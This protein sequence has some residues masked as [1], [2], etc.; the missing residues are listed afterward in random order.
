ML[1]RHIGSYFDELTYAMEWLGK[2]QDTFFIGQ[3]VGY[4]GTSM[5]NT[6]KNVTNDKRLELPVVEE[7]QMGISCGLALTGFVP[8]SIFPRWN[9]L[10]C[11]ISGLVNH[12]DKYSILSD[13]G[14]N[15]HVIIRT[16]IGSVLPLDPQ[17]Q[18]KGDFTEAIQAMCKTV[19]VRRLERPED[20][21][22]A[23]MTAYNEKGVHLL[24]E[25][26]DFLNEDFRKDYSLFRET[27]R[28]N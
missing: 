21:L 8:I 1:N 19:K 24:C 16:G 25:V 3:A 18:H 22:P 14:Y 11:A 26:S 7:T 5:F 17:Y 23:Y 13:G 4:P 28:G 9:F 15:P 12:L 10:L 20:I 2:K 6:L 27:Y